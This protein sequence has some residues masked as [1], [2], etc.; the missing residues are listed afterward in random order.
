METIAYNFH[1][2]TG[3]FDKIKLEAGLL[4]N[5]FLLLLN[6]ILLN[7]VFLIL[8]DDASNYL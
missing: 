6:K 2:E 1:D 5:F 4:I 3:L 8:G 7:M